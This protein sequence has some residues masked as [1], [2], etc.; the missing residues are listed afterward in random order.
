MFRSKQYINEYIHT[1]PYKH[2]SMSL[3]VFIIC[4]SSPHPFIFQNH[5][6]HYNNSELQSYKNTNSSQAHHEILVLVLYYIIFLLSVKC[7]LP[8]PILKISLHYS[9]HRSVTT[10]QQRLAWSQPTGRINSVLTQ[11]FIQ[12]FEHG[13]TSL[14]FISIRNSFFLSQIIN[15]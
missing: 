7:L 3:N 6:L 10:F 9:G 12:T 5:L 14:Y 13:Q 11:Y 8:S 15:P 2:L 1:C 4:T